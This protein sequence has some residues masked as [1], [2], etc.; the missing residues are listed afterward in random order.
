M[1]IKH[2]NKQQQN[3]PKDMCFSKNGGVLCN[4]R[5]QA[6]ALPVS[7]N[8]VQACTMSVLL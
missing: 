2:V 8:T 4:S 3:Q 5:I 1:C 6:K 7:E